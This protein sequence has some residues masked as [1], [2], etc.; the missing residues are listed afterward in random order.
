MNAFIPQNPRVVLQLNQDCE[1]VAIAN[2]IQSSLKVE[3]V[4]TDTSFNVLIKG[5]PF[6]S[7]NSAVFESK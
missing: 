7:R 1:V 5:L 4:Y 2:N 6:D 3:V